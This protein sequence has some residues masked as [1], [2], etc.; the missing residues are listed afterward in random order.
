MVAQYYDHERD[1]FN[2]TDCWVKINDLCPAHF[3]SSIE[4]CY[5]LEGE[6]ATKLDGKEYILKEHDIIVCQSYSVHQYEC[7]NSKTIIMTIPLDFIP[8][9]KPTLSNKIFQNVKASL[10][11]NNE[12]LFA[13]GRLCKVCEQEEKNIGLLKGYTYTIIG[14]LCDFLGLQEVKENTSFEFSRKVLMYLEKNYLEVNDALAVASHFG[15]SKSHF[16]HLFSESLGFGFSEYINYLKCRH[17]AG[18]LSQNKTNM[19][20]IAMDSGF[21]NIRSFYRNFKQIYSLTPSEF[22]A[23]LSQKKKI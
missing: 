20:D 11:E 18:L 12:I 23:S 7:T 3:H 22:Q 13:L 5:V 15:Y 16:L 1:G 10:P 2:H 14:I 21:G 17:A 19:L 9:M 8:S 6:V 4:L